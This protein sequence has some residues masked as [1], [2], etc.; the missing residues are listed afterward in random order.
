MMIIVASRQNR[1]AASPNQADG[2]PLTEIGQI[3]EGLGAQPNDCA[4]QK[5]VP[6]VTAR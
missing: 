2:V 5:N 1:N 3:H 6:V 4:Q